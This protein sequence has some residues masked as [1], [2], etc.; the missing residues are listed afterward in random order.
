MKIQVE[1]EYEPM[2]SPYN[3]GG[4]LDIRALIRGLRETGHNVRT[5]TM[6]AADYTEL[7]LT[8]SWCGATVAKALKVGE[9]YLDGVKFVDGGHESR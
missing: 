5:V 3:V 2:D 4:L 6:T 7:V 8:L 9:F 1:I